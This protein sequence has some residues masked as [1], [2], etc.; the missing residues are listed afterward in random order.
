M[1]ERI[2]TYSSLGDGQLSRTIATGFG[3]PTRFAY[4]AKH[5]C[6]LAA[7]APLSASRSMSRSRLMISLLSA[8]IED[9]LVSQED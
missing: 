2:V 5:R 6:D 7:A 1:F 9:L 4:C 3:S 8:S